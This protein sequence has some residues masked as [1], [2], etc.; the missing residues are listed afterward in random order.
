MLYIDR[1]ALSTAKSNYSTYATRMTT[2]KINLEKAVTDLRAGWKTDAGDAFFQKYDNEWVKNLTDYI[3]VINHM[4]NN[5][6]TATDK[7]QEVFD[8][9]DKLKL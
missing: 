3:N 6:K 8:E 5:M 9:A 2:L 7:Y 1:D 4:S